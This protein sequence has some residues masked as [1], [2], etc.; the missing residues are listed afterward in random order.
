M[1]IA[2]QLCS[3]VSELLEESKKNRRLPITAIVG[4]VWSNFHK[5]RFDR[6][7]QDLWAAYPIAIHTPPLLQ[8][9]AK[10]L[11]QLLLDRLLKRLIAAEARDC[12]TAAEP[13]QQIALT[14][15]EQIECRS[16]HG[17]LHSEKDENKV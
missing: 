14:L 17:W 12:S 7:I 2:V 16:V 13:K 11:L 5:L 6:R 15:Q 4:K 10:L 8:G 3:R 9:E 1:D